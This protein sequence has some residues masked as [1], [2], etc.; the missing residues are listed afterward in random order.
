MCQQVEAADF[1]SEGS[2]GTTEEDLQPVESFD[3]EALAGGCCLTGCAA[4]LQAKPVCHL[5]PIRLLEVVSKD[6]CKGSVG[7]SSPAPM[8]LHKQDL[9]QAQPGMW[10]CARV[11]LITARLNGFAVSPLAAAKLLFVP[12]ISASNT[13]KAEHHRFLGGLDLL[14]IIS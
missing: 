12:A 13:Y 2:N 14:F 6:G 3:G 8:P 9:P 7:S 5:C 11:V 4:P 10:Q 1:T